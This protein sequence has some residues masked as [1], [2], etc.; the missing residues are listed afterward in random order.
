M[1]HK[2]PNE[3]KDETLQTVLRKM[4]TYAENKVDS[5]MMPWLLVNGKRTMKKRFRC[6]FVLERIWGGR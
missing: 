4:T 3:V 1:G 6:E 2:V 5:L